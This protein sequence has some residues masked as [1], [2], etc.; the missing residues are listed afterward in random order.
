MAKIE[1]RHLDCTNEKRFC[2]V[3]VVELYSKKAIKINIWDITTNK[4]IPIIFDES[5]AIKFSKSLRTEIN[6]LKG[7]EVEDGR[8]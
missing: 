3:E 2:T 5:T 8:R 1:L 4:I 7:K 6:K